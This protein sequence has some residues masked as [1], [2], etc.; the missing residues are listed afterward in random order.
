MRGGLDIG[1]PGKKKDFL[2]INRGKLTG[3]IF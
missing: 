2:Q 3:D 1:N